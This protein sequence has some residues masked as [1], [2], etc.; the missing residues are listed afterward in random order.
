MIRVTELAKDY[1]MGQGAVKAL[2]GISLNI[3]KGEFCVLL[4]PSGCGK[5]TTLRCVAGL[6]QPDSGE[7]VIEDTVVNSPQRNLYV[8]PEDRGIGG[9]SSGAIAAFTVAWHRPDQFS[10]VLSTIGSFWRS[11]QRTMAKSF[12]SRP[13]TSLKNI[14]SA[15]TA[16]RIE[17]GAYFFCS[18]R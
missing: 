13:R 3:E 11:G 9:A 2:R 7:I 1:G 5:T 14:C 8:P 12:Q 16:M 15:A 17:L 18:L 6:E 4:G 10:K